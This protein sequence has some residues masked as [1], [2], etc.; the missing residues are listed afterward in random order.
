RGVEPPRATGESVELAYSGLDTTVDGVP[1]D[2]IDTADLDPAGGRDDGTGFYVGCGTGF[3]VDRGTGLEVDRARFHVDR[4]ARLD[5]NRARFHV[6]RTGLDVDGTRL[7]INR[8][9]RL[10]IHP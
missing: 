5:V 8:R 3:H 4:G 10:H 7:H 1:A 6:D 9:P 2:R